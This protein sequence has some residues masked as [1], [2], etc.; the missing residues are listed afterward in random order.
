MVNGR[1]VL[2]L[3]N[4][5]ALYP[6][7]EGPDF[8]LG[9]RKTNPVY[10]AGITAPVFT[11]RL[12]VDGSLDRYE[13][14]VSPKRLPVIAEDVRR[15][16]RGSRRSSLVTIHDY[17][18]LLNGFNDLGITL[19][20]DSDAK[21]WEAAYIRSRWSARLYPI[22]AIFHTI[23]YHFMLHSFILPLLLSQSYPCDSV[24]CFSDAARRALVKL[25]ER[26]A[27][28]FGNDYKV[29]LKYR[30]RLDVIPL[31]V[32]T[33]LFRPRNKSSIRRQLGLPVD[34]CIILY[35]GRF[36][37]ID[38]MDL[39]PTLRVVRDLMIR[40]PSRN[41]L[42]VLAG[43]SRGTYLESMKHYLS[44]LDM[45]QRVKIV[46]A[47]PEDRHLLFSAA[48]IFVSPSD[49]IQENL[50]STPIEAMASGVPQ[51]VADWNGYRESVRH[52]ETGFL[53]P[54]CWTRCDGDLSDLAPLHVMNVE[55]D[56]GSMAQSVAMDLREYGRCLEALI[57]NKSL[58]VAMGRA[59][60]KRAMECYSWQS[61]VTKYEE[62]A[63]ELAAIAKSG[64]YEP[65][66]APSYSCP[67][68]FE[69][70][71]HYATKCLDDDTLM[72]LSSSTQSEGEVLPEYH[73]ALEGRILD[74]RIVTAVINAMTHG[75]GR[76][77]QYLR[78][79]PASSHSPVAMAEVVLQV[80]SA[81]GRH[82]DEIRRH[83]MWL[84]KNGVVEIKESDVPI[85]RGEFLSL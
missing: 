36:S 27:T 25:L 78:E 3:L 2:G 75:N 18:E 70:F 63:S 57:V 1:R 47:A 39:F 66:R 72:Y 54:V 67:S 44:E 56:H 48:D 7:T 64:S 37:F 17:R 52:G 9:I 58:R 22:T 46:A 53:V 8:Y 32:D 43:T 30:G 80:E 42:L 74:A 76:D 29:S 4:N 34:A 21:F 33:Q 45:L 23:S 5:M 19:W 61:V 28:K 79:K 26:V 59:S 60:R 62:I 83:I 50:G 14:F 6:D 51:V 81:L 31:G 85:N 69:T 15:A 71:G 11:K 65:R 12:I 20:F 35:L 41:T 77:G 10:G 84:L 82:A 13:M 73:P 49:S 55:F 40:H 24:I 16:L 38:K 68:Y